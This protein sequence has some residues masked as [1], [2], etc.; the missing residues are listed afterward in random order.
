MNNQHKWTTTTS[1][2]WLADATR[3]AVGKEF[4]N[5]A[6]PFSGRRQCLRDSVWLWIARLPITSLRVLPHILCCL[7][8]MH[9][10]AN[11]NSH[12][13]RDDSTRPVISNHVRHLLLIRG[14]R[15]WSAID[16]TEKIQEVKYHVKGNKPLSVIDPIQLHIKLKMRLSRGRS[17]EGSTGV[18]K[19]L[20]VRSNSQKSS[21][22]QVWRK[23]R[24]GATRN[25]PIDR[26]RKLHQINPAQEKKPQEWA[27][28]RVI[29]NNSDRPGWKKGWIGAQ[30]R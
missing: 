6:H 9:L 25:H 28:N 23:T 21:E 18:K 12:W 1:P 19:A 15:G 17:H 30:Y 16:M 26:R 27:I 3:F 7:W 14:S 11:V 2:W 5:G 22:E 29:E 24:N 4:L 13:L 10:H 8:R 20:T